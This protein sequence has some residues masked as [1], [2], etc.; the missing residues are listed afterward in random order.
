MFLD[1]A[2][3][4]QRPQAVVDAVTDYYT[5]YNANIHRGIY[6]LSE[7]ATE[8]YEAVRGQ[9]ADFIGA[10][11]LHEIVFTRNA[12]E[13]INLVA[14]TWARS[15]LSK[16]D[17]VLI[18]EM[19]HHSNIVPW[20]MGVKDGR[21]KMDVVKMNEDFT[22]DSEDYKEKL[23]SG[24]VKLVALSHMSNVLGTVNNVK[25]LMQ[26]A[27]D[28]GALVLVD[29]AQAVPH[30]PVNVSELGADFYVFS[31]HKMLGPTGV[32]VLWARKELLEAMPPFLGGGDMIREV[33]FA[34]T[35]YNDVPWKFEAGTPN[36]AGVIGLGAAVEYLSN[37]SIEKI[38]EHEQELIKYAL[39]K[40]GEQSGLRVIGPT[41]DILRGG[42][43]SFTL[44]G[45]HPHDLAS[46]LNDSHIAIRAGHHCAQP[47]HTSLGLPATARA[48]FYMYNDRSDVDCLCEGIIQARQI[49]T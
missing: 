22:L 35:E 42:A 20:Q 45:I 4:S 8:R 33:S 27:H 12:T 30:M 43:V 37:L 9:V 18:T 7:K 19:E 2:A 21:W 32:G 31:A 36:I 28:A 44:E 10:P 13:S 11:D 6:D 1:S 17:T 24:S 15:N 34:Q 25:E 3:S 39:E 46:V 47:L 16:D 48:S 5:Q 49:F 14:H 29:G 26:L 23:S 40:L 41:G 38:W